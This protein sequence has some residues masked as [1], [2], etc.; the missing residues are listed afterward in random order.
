[1]WDILD[2]LALFKLVVSAWKLNF[3]QYDWL[4]GLG[5]RR[6]TTGLDHGPPLEVFLGSTVIKLDPS[7]DKSSFTIDDITL[8]SSFRTGPSEL[9]SDD[10]L[11]FKTERNDIVIVINFRGTAGV[12]V[13]YYMIWI[14]EADLKDPRKHIVNAV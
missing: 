3:L 14:D 7:S 11:S 12:M 6:G 9:E 4:F 8:Y 5:I 1:M 13:I 2:V 10:H